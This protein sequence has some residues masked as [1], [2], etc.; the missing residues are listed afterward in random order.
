M[1]KSLV[2]WILFYEFHYKLINSISN[3][4]QTV[5]S[6]CKEKV[7]SFIMLKLYN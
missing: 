7:S 2:A 6:I 3:I 5:D 4:V 1:G